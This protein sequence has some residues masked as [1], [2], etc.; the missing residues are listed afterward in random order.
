MT[1]TFQL[2]F[3]TSLFPPLSNPTPP[4]QLETTFFILFQSRTLF[5]WSPPPLTLSIS[6]EGWS[7]VSSPTAWVGGHTETLG[8]TFFL[9]DKMRRGGAVPPNEAGGGW[10]PLARALFS[11]SIVLI[12]SIFVAVLAGVMTSFVGVTEPLFCAMRTFP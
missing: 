6:R 2:C 7:G 8:S 5:P 1:L 4:R 11:V 3:L 10:G 9:N 12:S